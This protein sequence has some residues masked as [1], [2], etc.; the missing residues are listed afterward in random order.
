MVV[1]SLKTGRAARSFGRSVGSLSALHGGCATSTVPVLYCSVYSTVRRVPKLTETAFA[2]AL[3]SAAQ[4]AVA[5]VAL[6]IVR[7]A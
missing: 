6:L 7:T 5:A 3:D 2:F 1:G 4:N